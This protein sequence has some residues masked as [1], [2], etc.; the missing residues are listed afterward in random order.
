MGRIQHTIWQMTSAPHMQIS[1]HVDR[2]SLLPNVQGSY[3]SL[4]ALGQLPGQSCTAINVGHIP[5]RS[6]V[7]CSHITRAHLT[8]PTTLV[9]T[10]VTYVL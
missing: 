5:R 6:L 4:T 7:E 3:D 9:L 2:I 8:A 1:S 10:G